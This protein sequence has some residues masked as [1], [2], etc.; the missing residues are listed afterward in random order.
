MSTSEISMLEKYFDLIVSTATVTRYSMKKLVRDESVMEHI[1]VVALMAMFIA[2]DCIKAGYQVDMENLLTAAL[3]HDLEESVIG[4]VPTT[5]KYANQQIAFE[6]N[7]LS[8]LT[9]RTIMLEIDHP[10]LVSIWENQK[11]ISIEGRILKLCDLFSVIMKLR[12]EVTNYGNLS[13]VDITKNC[14][15]NMGKLLEEEDV[16][17]LRAL[18]VEA[19]QICKSVI[20]E[21]YESLCTRS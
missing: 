7:H 17:P 19:N 20:G 14:C 2:R 8:R 3:V 9:I 10:V 6:L 13:I 12:E 16:P 15:L 21:L 5:T 4:D 1:G 18:I 11:N